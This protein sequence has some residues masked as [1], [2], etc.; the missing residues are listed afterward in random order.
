MM[1]RVCNTRPWE[2]VK[3]IGSRVWGSLT[4]I[5]NS[6]LDPAERRKE[7]KEGRERTGKEGEKEDTL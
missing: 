6:K 5:A 2:E 3:I 7:E 4:Y 1:L